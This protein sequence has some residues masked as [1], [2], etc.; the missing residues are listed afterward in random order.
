MRQAR[1]ATAVAALAEFCSA[2]GA[3][4]EQDVLGYNMDPDRYKAAC[5]DYKHFSMVFQYA[6]P[7]VY[8]PGTRQALTVYAAGHSAM[9]PFPSPFSVL[10]PIVEHSHHLPLRR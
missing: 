8:R 6:S 2:T 5:P 1:I 10:R 4:G 9:V 7:R 3:Y